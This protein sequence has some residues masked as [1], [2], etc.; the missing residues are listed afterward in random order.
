M[1]LSSTQCN[2]LK[3]QTCFFNT[4]RNTSLDG[5]DVFDRVKMMLSSTQ[6]NSLKIQTCFFNTTRNTSLD[7]QDPVSKHEGVDPLIHRSLHLV[8][9]DASFPKTLRNLSDHHHWYQHQL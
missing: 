6:C 1:M 7:G 3:I 4:T 2:S 5:Q 8:H 9:H